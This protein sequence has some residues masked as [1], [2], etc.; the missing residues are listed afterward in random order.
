MRRLRRSQ[1]VAT[2]PSTRSGMSALCM[3]MRL[4][5]RR[6]PQ[7]LDAG[8]PAPIGR[9]YRLD[10]G[11]QARGADEGNRCREQRILDEVLTVLVAKQAARSAEP[12]IGPRPPGVRHLRS[13]RLPRVALR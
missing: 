5:V 6:L 10:D 13:E 9:V 12:A 11:L 2:T 7:A 1:V 3:G 4:G 8:V